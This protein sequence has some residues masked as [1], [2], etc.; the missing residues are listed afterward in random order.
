M[1]NRWFFP[2]EKA[3][4]PEQRQLF[5]K[6]IESSLQGWETHGEP[7]FYNVDLLYNQILLIEAITPVSG[8]AIDNL[9]KRIHAC[10]NANRHKVLPY[11]F[12]FFL[13]D[14]KLNY[15]DFREIEKH[16]QT[17]T[18]STET[19]VL[20]TQKLLQDGSDYWTKVGDSWLVKFVSA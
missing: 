17:G 11:H 13:Q 9:Y 2:L 19:L 7:I 15:F 4:N 10:L 3:L 6:E 8:C 18:I 14:G 12:V 5:L 16:L 20:D 1:T